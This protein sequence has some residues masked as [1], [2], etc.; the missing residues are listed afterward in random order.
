MISKR[1]L[2]YCV[3]IPLLG[4]IGLLAC[5]SEDAFHIHYSGYEVPTPHKHLVLPNVASYQQTTN[6]TCGPSAV[7]TLMR[8]YGK[9][10]AS[11]MNRETEMRI[12]KEMNTS[13]SGTSQDDIVAW[14]RKNGFSVDSGQHIDIDTLINNINKGIPT[15]I[16]W[17]DFSEHAIVVVGYNSEGE[18]PSG[19]KDVIFAADPE[20]GS[21][22][23]ENGSTIT[24]VDSLTPDQLELNQANANFFNPSHSAIG[25]YI[26]AVPR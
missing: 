11:D 1:Q 7:M 22:I 6:Y 26:T 12:A 3:L 14:L 18:S 4:T 2:L 25:T 15:I 5:T 17:N 19:N 9:L 16:T 23:E 10:N 13:I 8:Y 21:Y 20:S 24:G